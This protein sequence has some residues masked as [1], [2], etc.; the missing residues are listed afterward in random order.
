ME[1]VIIWIIL[2]AVVGFIANSKGKSG[3]AWFLYGFLLWPIA[4]V[5]IL[6]ARP[7]SDVIEQRELK[8][9]DKKKCPHCAELIR[10]DAKVCRYC[11]RELA[12]RGA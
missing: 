10:S 2:G 5:H 1:F 11:S 7:N 6:V 12:G 8:S 4:L 3:L 9:G